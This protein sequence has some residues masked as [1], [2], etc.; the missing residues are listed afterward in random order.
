M[1]LNMKDKARVEAQL[2]L[3]KSFEKENIESKN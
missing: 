3:D 1:K 2:I